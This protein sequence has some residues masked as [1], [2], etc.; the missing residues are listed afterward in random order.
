MAQLLRTSALA[1]GIAASAVN[2]DV[3]LRRKVAAET[4]AWQGANPSAVEPAHAMQRMRA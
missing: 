4:T 2:G 1:M 3:T